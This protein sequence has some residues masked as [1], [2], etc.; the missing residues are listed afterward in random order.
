MAH[1]SA[2]EFER[3]EIPQ[4]LEVCHAC[5]NR[6]CVNVDHLFLGTHRENMADAQRKLRM[7]QGEA[8][9]HAKLTTSDVI[10]IRKSH[11]NKLQLAKLYDVDHKTIRRVIA[12][13]TWKSVPEE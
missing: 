12:R 2:W 13:V 9:L 10:A 6:S 7:R 5:D 3:G 4:G 1:R 11:L 8:Q